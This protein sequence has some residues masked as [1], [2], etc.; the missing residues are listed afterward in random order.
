MNYK[1]YHRDES[2]LKEE[3]H[4]KNIFKKRFNIICCHFERSRK[5]PFRVL[6]IGTSTGTMLDIFKEKGWETWGIEPSQSAK[7]AAKKGHK[8][9]N[10]YFE[11]LRDGKQ[12]QLPNN[13]FD[14]SLMNHTLEHLD[15]PVL[16]LKKI[17]KIL[18]KDGLIL[19]DV[20]NA[21]GLGSRILKDKWPYRLPEEHKHQF[22]KQ[23]LSKIFE[24]AGFQVIHF[25]SR[26]GIF[27]F[28]SPFKEI[29]EALITGKKRFFTDI[30]NI[31]YDTF[32]TFF[33]SGDSMT[34]VGKK[35]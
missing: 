8:I 11:N 26:S 18:K 14:L 27:E 9:I 10:D 2:Y 19:I 5:I 31:P 6:D 7:V 35:I 20:P 17:H 30:L 1:K 13:Y 16:I 28:A 24:I 25:E 23:S 22:T 33:D 3:A 29:L 15:D 21:G 12:E 34:M 4:F 32:V